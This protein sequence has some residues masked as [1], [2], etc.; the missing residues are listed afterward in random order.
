M[1]DNWNL[2]SI[3]PLS[4][5][6]YF[7][8]SERI[9]GVLRAK[10]LWKKVM[11]VKPAIKPEE[12]DPEY[13][14]KLK[15]WDEWD[16]NNA[17][18]RAIIVNTM[19]KAQLLKY[20]HIK[21][22]DK[23]W[24]DIKFN[25]AA[26]T[27]Q[28]KS[29]SL[30]ELTNLRMQKHESVDDYINRA[31]ALRNQCVQLGKVIEDFEL[32]MYILKGLRQ[33]YD[34]N[35]RILEIQKEITI[36]DIRY[37]LKQ[38]ELRNEVR[39]DERWKSHENVRKVYEKGRNDI[40]CFNCGKRGHKSRDCYSKP[41]C[42]NCHGMNHTAA[43]CKEIRR[44]TP[45]PRRN[46]KGYAQTSQQRRPG[47]NGRE[48]L[49]ISLRTNE[50]T[51]HTVRDHSDTELAYAI[52][53]ELS[54]N[55]QIWLLDS[56]STSHMTDNMKIFDNL[57]E[58]ERKITLADKDGKK[59]SSEGIGEIVIKQ[60][61]SENN[62]RLK[63]VLC[64]PE[65]NTN[66][67]SVA[68]ITDNDYNVRFNKFG[69][70]VYKEP[71]DVI[72][73][74]ARVGNAYYVRSF[75]VE[76][77]SA[78]VTSD[79]KIWHKRLGHVNMKIVEEMKKEDVVIGMR[80]TTVKEPCESCVEGKTQRKTHHRI[81]E[82][83][84]NSIMEMWHIDLVGP[85]YPASRGGKRY[86]FTIIDDYSRMIFVM[87]LE[88]KR[89]AADKLKQLIILKENQTSLKLKVVRSDNG[90]EFLGRDLKDW[91]QRK[92]IKHELS[93]PRTPQSNGVIERAN[94][95]IIEMTRSMI[96][97]SK[98]PLD[99]WG[100][101]AYTAAHI[102]NRVK[103]KVHDMTPYEVW[104]KKKPNIRY[105]RRFG[106]T[107]YLLQKGPRKKFES[108]TIKGIFLGY[109]E[110]NTYRVY[111]PETDKVKSDCDVQ[112]DENKNGSELLSNE[113]IEKHGD[114]EQLVIIGLEAEDDD[115]EEENF[116]E[117]D[118]RTDSEYE[119]A[120]EGTEYYPEYEENEGSVSNEDENYE[121]DQGED[122]T[123]EIE[124]RIETRGRGR[125]KGTTKQVMVTRRKQENERRE[126]NYNESGPR[127]SERIKRN[128][129]M[130]VTTEEI[131]KTVT[132]AKRLENWKYWKHAMEE[133]M[134]S[135]KK[136]KVW[137]VVPRQ[138]G[139]RVIKSKW[140]FN[141]K[142]N[143]NLNERQYK[144]RLVAMGCGQRPGYDYC[145]TFAPTIRMETMR[146]L[147]SISAEVK[148]KLKIYD[149]KT[150]FLHGKLSEEVF[151]ELP[152][153][154]E[155]KNDRV[156]KLNKSIY[157]LKQA[158]K[159]WN[160][161]LTNI[162]LNSGLKQSYEDP[163]LFYV[164]ER[165]DFLYCGVHV[166]D[167]ATVSSSDEYE[168]KFMNKVKSKV[169]IKDIG[170]GKSILGMEIEYGENKL[171][172]HQKDYIRQLLHTYGMTDCNV[173]ATPVDINQKLENHEGSEECDVRSF[174]EL[175]GKLM[176]LS[177]A[178][179]PDI[180][181][182]MSYLSQFNK[183]PKRMHM[184]ALKRVLRY[185]K[186]TIN[187]KLEFGKEDSDN[188]I[189]CQTDASWDRTE[190]AKSFSGILV[191]RRGDLIHWRSR[192]QPR[193]ALSS[194]ESELEA[195]VEGV[196]EVVWCANLLEEIEFQKVDMKRLKC[197]NLNC[198]KLANGGNFK[199]KTKLLN[200]K[201]YYVRETVREQSID[202][203]HIPNSAMSAD[204]LTKP[205][206][207]ANLLKNV[208]NFMK[209]L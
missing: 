164:R 175:I 28:L 96:S 115:D 209:E 26:G 10:K 76:N 170:E 1:G 74:A 35:V 145:E 196:K 40:E 27:E 38:E 58:E 5:S 25:M 173:A 138:K 198:V 201:S 143:L 128:Q 90:G 118:I 67:L 93:P 189:E 106:C 144:A 195:M 30:S 194:T 136:H 4:N 172:V 91:L 208:Q 99:F 158:S 203:M 49:E 62:V 197:D 131:P 60:S 72:M 111:I 70:I 152:D 121:M 50:E 75:V 125:P 190:D 16:D 84:T 8:W 56:G 29:R 53:E 33:E 112:F 11:G 162:L 171:Y 191:F 156:C 110:N 103:S 51:I 126:E 107:A 104:Y 148:R 199:T 188:A 18:A 105:L 45:T 37:A 151:M 182:A 122:H 149:V 14:R 47:D 114:E 102:K 12:D 186:G 54:N 166:D 119:D 17:A 65:L 142:E 120:S 100:E 48:R 176:Y 86:I 109:A 95:S 139:K 68:K 81:G 6:N 66:L 42:F 124:K 185:L 36:N 15:I 20:T 79:I 19:D 98:L 61:S 193:V 146:I 160:D 69:A 101:A 150:A 169:E 165:E 87:L 141:I 59:L 9:E 161:C 135:M 43:M 55:D 184:T 157:G 57:E 167:M 63:N 137:D 153:G 133:E 205:V 147:F 2:T 181:F 64:V 73:T 159:C 163:C 13:E 31:E 92:G 168:K 41:R 24:N 71:N 117:Q 80:D 127:R 108:K 34:K 179:R 113:Y 21:E 46:H 129:V 132:E 116:V 178:T 82:R 177:V 32:R 123:E 200:R 204:C 78:N 134:A 44:N 23:L 207:R 174:Q 206:S 88:Y 85:I 7:L 89:E 39:K 77:E 83:K 140:I 94:R 130:K 3:E 183:N 97:D 187:Y 155:N 180:S 22:A 154:Y 202:V 52:T 192:K